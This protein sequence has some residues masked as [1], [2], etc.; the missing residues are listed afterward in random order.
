MGARYKDTV[1]IISL[2]SGSMSLQD[3]PFFFNSQLITLMYGVYL[4][5]EIIPGA[6]DFML[7]LYYQQMSLEVEEGEGEGMSG[8]W[9]KD[10]K[11]RARRKTDRIELLRHQA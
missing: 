6:T 8:S 2:L 3:V 7:C 4:F 1:Y 5:Y 11:R 10:D 9:K